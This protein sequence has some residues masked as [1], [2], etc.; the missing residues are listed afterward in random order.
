MFGHTLQILSFRLPCCFPE[1]FNNLT[2]GGILGS[3][4]KTTNGI[5]RRL[6]VL[7]AINRDIRASPLPVFE[8]GNCLLALGVS[9]FSNDPDRLALKEKVLG[10]HDVLCKKGF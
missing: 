8:A 6:I 7:F 4:C 10:S 3:M 1:V 2:E 5:I 9:C